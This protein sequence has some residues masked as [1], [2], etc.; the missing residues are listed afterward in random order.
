MKRVLFAA[1]LLVA[2]V[3]SALGGD[4]ITLDR[5]RAI[6][7]GYSA[8]LEVLTGA[9]LKTAGD[10]FNAVTGRDAPIKSAVLVTLPN[11][12]G[13]LL[14]VGPDQSQLCAY[15]QLDARQWRTLR[16]SIFGTGA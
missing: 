7:A 8:K 15:G 16:N 9:Q 5:A 12:D 3:A 1:A 13:G 2:S 4:C 11:G 6:A 10:I 14:A